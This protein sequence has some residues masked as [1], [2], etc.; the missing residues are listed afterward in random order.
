[1]W[2][3]SREAEVELEQPSCYKARTRFAGSPQPLPVTRQKLVGRRKGAR[4]G[5]Q[6]QKNSPVKCLQILLL[7]HLSEGPDGDQ[8]PQREPLGGEVVEGDG[9]KGRGLF[10]SSPGWRIGLPVKSRPTLA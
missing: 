2:L 9:L 4:A 10:T 1:M 8:Q 5:T 7:N 3:L 6:R